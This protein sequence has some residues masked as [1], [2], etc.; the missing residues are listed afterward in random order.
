MTAFNISN[1]DHAATQSALPELPLTPVLRKH[2]ADAARHPIS[3]QKLALQ[4]VAQKARVWAADDGGQACRPWYMLILELYPRGKVINHQIH[5]PASVPPPTSALLTFLLHHISNPPSPATPI[6]PTH[7][8]FVDSNVTLA[9]KSHLEK[10]AMVVDTLTLADGVSDY[11]RMFADKLVESDRA[12]RSDA[13]ERPGLLSNPSV[14]SD[15]VT[16][17]MTR[18]VRMHQIQPWNRIPEYIA[19]RVTLPLQPEYASKTT[20]TDNKL[21]MYV[22]VLGGEGSVMGFAAVPSLSTLRQK[23]RRVM[24]GRGKATLDVDAD[25]TD[26]ADIL[27]LRRI[28]PTDICLCAACGAPVASEATTEQGQTGHWAWRCAQCRF[29]HYCDRSCQR[30]DWKRRHRAECH[31][32]LEAENDGSSHNYTDPVQTNRTKLLHARRELAQARKEWSWVYRELALLFM[33]PTAVPFDDLDH[34]DTFK[35]PYVSS[36][37]PPLYPLPFVSVQDSTSFSSRRD[38]PSYNEVRALTLIANALCQCTSVPSMDGSV[39]LD[40]DVV[41][42]VAENLAEAV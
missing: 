11:M 15:L 18:A 5:R 29:V 38:L 4:V 27:G 3:E 21:T 7:V 34:F 19:L 42:S 39:H 9:V 36:A 22:S 40:G 37:S 2:L 14:T 24:A 28:V 1:P 16:K 33:D 12:T 10:L 25:D 35:W 8:S 17:L 6:R 20:T 30:D 41:I 13:A 32:L 26:D 31:R 23:F